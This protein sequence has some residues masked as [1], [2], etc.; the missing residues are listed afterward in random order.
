M[1][2]ND[3]TFNFPNALKVENS[4]MTRKPITSEDE[5]PDE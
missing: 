2:P 3:N 1:Q 4:E 5:L